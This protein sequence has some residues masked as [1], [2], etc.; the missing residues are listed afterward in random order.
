M[1]ISQLF[2]TFIAYKKAYK[3]FPKERAKSPPI[4]SWLGLK[5]SSETYILSPYLVGACNGFG[6][7]NQR[8]LSSQKIKKEKRKKKKNVN[9]IITFT[10]M[11]LLPNPFLNP[12]THPLMAFQQMHTL[13]STSRLRRLAGIHGLQ[14]STSL[15][16][17][18][19]CRKHHRHNWCRQKDVRHIGGKEVVENE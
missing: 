11:L 5:A 13:T 2:S 19:D 1:K 6:R 14:Y 12:Q 9:P 15:S 16:T 10:S 7:H 8:G 3:D 18:F 4:T 17:N